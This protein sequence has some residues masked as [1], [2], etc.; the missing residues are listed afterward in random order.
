MLQMW[1]KRVMVAA[2]LAFT[3]LSPTVAS[4]GAIRIF[5][6]SASGTAQSGAFAAQAD[7]PSA[8][9]FN[10]AGLTQLRGVQTSFGVM[11]LGGHTTY[12]S[13]TGATATGDFGG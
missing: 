4:A 11:L 9:Y 8:V 1:L 6:Q 12:T 10:P 2:S 13:P 5:D 7:D 3:C